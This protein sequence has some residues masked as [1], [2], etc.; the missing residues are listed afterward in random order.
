[1]QLNKHQRA[2]VLFLA[3]TFRPGLSG[4]GPAGQSGC[5]P[6]PLSVVVPAIHI[7]TRDLLKE[8][9]RIAFE[10]KVCLGLEDTGPDQ[11]ISLDLPTGSMEQIVKTVF[12]K[13]YIVVSDLVINVRSRAAAHS[14]LDFKLKS[15]QVQRAS[16]DFNSMQL[17]FFLRD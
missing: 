5:A 2:V 9:I 4:A 7:Q 14:W 12:P 3:I 13:S 8:V 11:T 17:F 6:N 10:N 16:L 15:F 1:M